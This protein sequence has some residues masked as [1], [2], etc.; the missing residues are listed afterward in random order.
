M[1]VDIAQIP[2]DD[3]KPNSVLVI[4]IPAFGPEDKVQIDVLTKG[5]REKLDES[6]SVLIMQSG[7]TF[8]V[9]PESVM[10]AGGWYRKESL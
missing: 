10:N 8:D 9:I 1:N 4:L 7:V 2:Y 6:I 3:I 5:L